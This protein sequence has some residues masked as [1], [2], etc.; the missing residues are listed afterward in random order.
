MINK[1]NCAYEIFHY[2]YSLQNKE[3][4]RLESE[5][6]AAFIICNNYDYCMNK[7]E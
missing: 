3:K 2:K 7:Y 5:V 1:L 6:K 4:D